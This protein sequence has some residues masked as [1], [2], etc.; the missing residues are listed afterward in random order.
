MFFKSSYETLPHDQYIEY[1]I[2][3]SQKMFT[4]KNTKKKIMM[5]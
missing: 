4:N 2:Y 3:S 5:Q 1:V